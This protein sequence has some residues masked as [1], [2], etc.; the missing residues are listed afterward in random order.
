MSVLR[1]R[2][3]KTY[4]TTAVYMCATYI[5]TYIFMKHTWSLDIYIFMKDIHIQLHNISRY[6]V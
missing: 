5:Q 1:N 2:Q 3:C 6:Y 4:N